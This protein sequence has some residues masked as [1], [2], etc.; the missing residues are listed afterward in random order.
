M[1]RLLWLLAG[2]LFASNA[3]A[4]SA[5][6]AVFSPTATDPNTATPIS[7]AVQLAPLCD[8]PLDTRE[9]ALNPTEG[10]YDDPARPGRECRVDVRAQLAAIAP[11]T[12][13]KAAVRVG[14][15]RY[16]AFSNAFA[17]AQPA[18]HP[19]DSTPTSPATIPAG[20]SLTLGW[21]HS[22]TD[23]SGTAA[24]TSW[25]VYRNNTLLTGVTVT[26]SATANAQGLRYYSISRT[27]SAA[28]AASFEVSGVNAVGEGA[29]AP[30]IAIS[31]QPSAT[32]PAAPS[33]GRISIP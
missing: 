33:S 26:T 30:A 2:I 15:G 18:A 27:E 4:Q 29:R 28:G 23:S 11:G 25:R 3:F 16:G 6:I 20:Q 12:G 7:S 24:V 5:T 21:C 31:V 14:T 10:A 19:C 1:K 13:Y 32:V 9:T 22:G 8:Q 17:L